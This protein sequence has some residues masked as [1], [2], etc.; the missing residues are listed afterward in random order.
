[1]IPMP[2]SANPGNAGIAGL[3][4]AEAP[5]PAVPEQGRRDPARPAEPL[6]TVPAAR[7]VVPSTNRSLE[8]AADGSFFL[9]LS[10]WS[11]LAHERR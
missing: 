6:P 9:C 7:W 3:L 5:R 8:S 10:H 11:E 2:N 1:M 4:P